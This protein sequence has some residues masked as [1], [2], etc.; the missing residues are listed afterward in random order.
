MKTETD[1]KMKEYAQ[2]TTQTINRSEINFAPYNPKKHS[3]E[4]IKAILKDI[5]KY[6]FY[7][8]VVWN[9]TTHNL[10]DGHKRIMALDLYHKYDG[11]AEKDYQIKVEVAEFDKQTE[12][13]RNVWHTK[14]QTPLDDDL[15]RELVPSLE[16]YQDAGLTDFDVSMY[17]YNI[18]DYS[19]NT[20]ENERWTKEALITEDNGELQKIYHQTKESEEN[21][22]IDRSVNFYEDT[23]EN[24]IARHNEIEKVKERIRNNDDD[25]GMLSYIVINF[26]NPKNKEAFCDRMGYAPLTKII[27]GE[28]FSEK[29]ERI[30]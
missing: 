11:S 24:Q 12:K 14:S 16:S 23:P 29:I 4:Q 28:D 20:G 19:M 22:K 21:K 2:S 17:V 6:G 30:D 15:M 3:E 26:Q 27:D 10:I 8:G 13:I 18:E 1:K 5:K 7:G 25:G 9:K